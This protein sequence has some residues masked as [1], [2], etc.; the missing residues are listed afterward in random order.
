MT[1]YALYVACDYLELCL[2]EFIRAHERKFSGAYPHY[3]VSKDDVLDPRTGVF[4]INCRGAHRYDLLYERVVF[5]GE[6]EG[7]L[8]W[9]VTENPS[10]HSLLRYY[11]HTF[12]YLGSGWYPKGYVGSCSE[13][14]YD[15]E[16]FT[17]HI[18]RHDMAECG[19]EKAPCDSKCLETSMCLV[20]GHYD[21]S[22]DDDLGEALVPW[23]QTRAEP[24]YVEKYSDDALVVRNFMSAL[25]RRVNANAIRTASLMH[26]H[27]ELFLGDA[28]IGNQKTGIFDIRRNWGFHR[29]DA[30]LMFQG[31]DDHGNTTWMNVGSAPIEFLRFRDGL[32]SFSWE[33]MASFVWL[34]S[35]C[36]DEC[37][38][39]GC[40]LCGSFT[41]SESE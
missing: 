37:L 17:L 7:R 22:S 35:P 27:R 33:Q 32:V 16:T 19:W 18:T 13:S 28:D 39:S 4:Y 12:D 2:R 20:C 14:F 21:Q 36:G 34:S 25:G 26:D 23:W 41:D 40:V 10:D 5:V 1:H 15:T 6:C 29:V 38:Y 24:A 30:R 8:T 11:T 31:N 3:F 9:Q